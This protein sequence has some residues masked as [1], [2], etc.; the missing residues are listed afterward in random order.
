MQGPPSPPSIYQ[1]PPPVG[2]WQPYGASLT[3]NIPGLPP[4]PPTN[5]PG[6]FPRDSISKDE[7]VIFETRPALITFILRPI[8]FLFF[9]SIGI[10]LFIGGI[11]D[12][13]PIL[14]VGM[15]LYLIAI[16]ID[17]IG[18]FLSLIIVWPLELAITTYTLASAIAI[19]VAGV[20]A[21]GGLSLLYNYTVWRNTNYALTQKRILAKTGIISRQSM[22]CPHDKVQNVTLKQGI[23]ERLLGFGTIIFSTAGIG[24]GILGW[25]RQ[26]MLAGGV[27]WRGIPDPINTR[28][29]VQEVVDACIK[30]KKKMEYE[31]MAKAFQQAGPSTQHSEHPQARPPQGV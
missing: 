6:S 13:S 25:Q 22:D 3:L 17:P 26:I 19:S 14:V 5:E 9:C 16:G 27:I 11:Y 24:G 7:S 21:G 15:I 18:W 10:A 12:D 20:I 1:P 31:E 4:P 8:L 2:S 23:F 28:R 30:Y 29:Y